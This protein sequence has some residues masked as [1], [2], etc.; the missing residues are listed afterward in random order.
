MPLGVEERS[1]HFFQAEE[2]IVA[3]LVDQAVGHDHRVVEHGQDAGPGKFRVADVRVVPQVGR[4]KRD[5]LQVGSDLLEG[6]GRI[7]LDD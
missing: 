4:L 2:P 1:P 6:G 3:V 5:D 7:A